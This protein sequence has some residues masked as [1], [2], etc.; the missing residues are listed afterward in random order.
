MMAS[1]RDYFPTNSLR[2]PLHQIERDLHALGIQREQHI[3]SYADA[4]H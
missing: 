2:L 1:R 3:E 4:A